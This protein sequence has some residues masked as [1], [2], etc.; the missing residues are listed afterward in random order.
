MD[1]F[2]TFSVWALVDFR[3]IEIF[4]NQSFVEKY[5]INNYRLS[6]SILVYNINGIPNNSQISKVVDIVLQYQFHSKQALFVVSS[7]DK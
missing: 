5:D 1:I 6:K 7:M 4:I 3:T 2:E